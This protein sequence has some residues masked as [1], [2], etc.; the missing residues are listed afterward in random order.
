MDAITIVEWIQALLILEIFLAIL[1]TSFK[2]W[3]CNYATPP[4]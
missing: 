4:R 1:A 3:R 2:V